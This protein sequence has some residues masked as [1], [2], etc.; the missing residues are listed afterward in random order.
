M[1]G[2]D[3]W[4]S[5][6]VSSYCHQSEMLWRGEDDFVFVY[7]CVG[8]LGILKCET[9][10]TRKIKYAS[11]FQWNFSHPKFVKKPSLRKPLL[12][13]LYSVPINLSGRK[14]ISPQRQCVCTVLQFL[15]NLPTWECSER[16][17]INTAL[18]GAE[19]YPQHFNVWTTKIRTFLLHYFLFTGFISKLKLML[20][21]MFPT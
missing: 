3:K 10:K 8:I 12:V 5:T 14:H 2:I 1:P 13:L 17:I 9:D 19:Q 16:Y 6:N 11:V 20:R 4:H 21:N 18:K 7:V 15:C